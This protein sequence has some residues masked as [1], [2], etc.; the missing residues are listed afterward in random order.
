MDPLTEVTSVLGPVAPESLGVTM[1]HEHTFL[2]VMREYRGDGLVHDAALVAADLREYASLGGRTIVDVT[3]RGLRAQPALLPALARD[4]GVTIIAGTGFYRHPFLDEAW[5]DRHSTDEVAD[6]IIRD[7]RDGIDD[8]GVRAGIIG[9]VGCDRHLTPVEE[10]SFRAAARA[11]HATGLTITTHAGRWPVGLPQLRLLR[12]E[13]VEPHRVIIGH[14]DMVLD[15]GYHRAI[16]EAGAWVQLDTIQAAPDH[17]LDRTVA[18]IR[19]L[20]DAGFEDR[21]LLSQDICLVSQFRAMGG[22]G[23]GYILREFAGR[24]RRAGIGEA[25][26]ERLLVTN[27]ARALT[28]A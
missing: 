13:G 19:A 26:L 4:T 23:Y 5:F 25:T 24:L 1:P 18:A 7:I 16:A 28:G 6:V 3:S 22:S 21:V 20:V 10:R 12:S 2:D 9:E 27:P 14:C 17:V 15:Q 8:T 11:H